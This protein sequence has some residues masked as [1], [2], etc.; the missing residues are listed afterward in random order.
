[1]VLVVWINIHLRRN[2]GRIHTTVIRPKIE[3]TY[4]CWQL[5]SVEK[6]IFC[7]RKFCCL[8]AIAYSNC[9]INIREM[10]S[11][12]PLS[13]PTTGLPTEQELLPLCHC[14]LSKVS[15]KWMS[16]LMEICRR[17][18][19]S[20]QQIIEQNGALMH[21]NIKPRVNGLMCLQ[22]FDAV[23][24]VSGRA[25][26]PEKSEWWGAGMVI[27]WSKVQIACIWFSWCHCHPIISASGMV[28]PSGTDVPGSPGQGVIN[29]C[30]VVP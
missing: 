13:S 11:Q 9:C 26:G 29:G 21:R 3:T 6:W 25:S 5:T 1:M 15:T 24:W 8:H 28:Y 30:S 7:W 20:Q 14:Q 12:S 2:T 22:C 18:P 16:I 17:V 23:V 19:H 27:F 4:L 10:T